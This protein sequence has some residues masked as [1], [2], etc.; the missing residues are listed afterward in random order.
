[1]VCVLVAQ[2]RLTLCDPTDHS[3]PGF[4]VHGIFQARILERIAIPFSKGTSQPRDRTL[5]SCITGKKILYCLSYREVV[6]MVVN[7]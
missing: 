2:S 6:P 3:P 5:V 4:S 7:I 1:M